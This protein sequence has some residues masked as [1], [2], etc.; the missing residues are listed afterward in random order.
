MIDT[1]VYKVVSLHVSGQLC[2]SITSECLLFGAST[3]FSLD[4]IQY[5]TSVFGKVIDLNQQSIIFSRQ[6]STLSLLHLAL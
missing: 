2:I 5:T 6:L 3:H 1:G 4:F